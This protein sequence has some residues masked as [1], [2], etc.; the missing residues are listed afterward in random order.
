MAF[1]QNQVRDHF[2]SDGNTQWLHATI[3][4]RLTKM[5]AS[6][7]GNASAGV[8]VKVPLDD[9]FL[10]EMQQVAENSLNPPQ[11]TLGLAA[12]NRTFINRMLTN[13]WQ[14]VTRSMLYNQYELSQNRPRTHPYGEY[15]AKDGNVT[16][17]SSAY[18]MSHPWAKQQDSFLMATTGLQPSGQASMS[19]PQQQTRG[20]MFV[21]T[22]R[23]CRGNQ[24][25][26]F[27]ALH[28]G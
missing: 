4:D 2:L 16:I 28:Q 18:N 1:L 9:F 5:L 24:G 22:E 19:A 20:Q 17:S 3:Q 13:L 27:M 8:P 10:V 12:M 6:V 7:Q 26:Q 25:Q 14:G 21:D 15:T 23:Y 11:G